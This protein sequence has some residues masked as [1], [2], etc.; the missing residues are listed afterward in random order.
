M[1]IAVGTGFV[2]DELFAEVRTAWSYRDLTRDEFDWALAFD[3]GGGSSLSAYPDYER[4]GRDPAGDE[5]DVYRVPR[6]DLARRHRMSIG[7]ITADTSMF[8]AWLATS[9]RIGQIEEGFIAR[10]KPGDVFVF[11]G[12]VLE[13]VRVRDMTAYV[14]KAKSQARAA[15]RPGRAAASR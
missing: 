4:I 1:T 15:C 14:K 12:R 9:G 10:M 6:A 7:T 8:V 5:P 11:G 3:E 2:A 13:L